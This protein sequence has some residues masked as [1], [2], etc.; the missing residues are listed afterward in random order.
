MSLASAVRRAHGRRYRHNAGKYYRT[1]LGGA[2]CIV[3]VIF[4]LFVI[5]GFPRIDLAGTAFL[6]TFTV[7]I[8]ASMSSPGIM[9]CMVTSVG[10][11]GYGLVVRDRYSL[12]V[13]WSGF[14][15]FFLAG[16]MGYARYIEAGPAV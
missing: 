8:A 9:L 5:I 7:G 15:L 4:F 2:V 10:L 12:A 16:C 1:L 11:M 6:L 14:V 13:F 3:A